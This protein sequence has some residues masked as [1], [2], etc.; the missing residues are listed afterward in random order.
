MIT[1]EGWKRVQAYEKRERITSLRRIVVVLLVIEIL[2]AIALA[3]TLCFNLLNGNIV[4]LLIA[5][6]IAC[7]ICSL[8]LWVYAQML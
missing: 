3:A 4:T 5:L 2:L 1:Y 8:I 7:G 6:M